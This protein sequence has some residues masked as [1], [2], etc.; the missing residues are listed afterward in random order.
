MAWQPFND[1]KRG[2]RWLIDADGV[3]QIL[4]SNARA[5]AIITYSRVVV[6]KPNDSWFLDS[7]PWHRVE[8]DWPKVRETVDK[9]SVQ[10][11]SNW[12]NLQTFEA[13]FEALV[14]FRAKAKKYEGIASDQLSLASK[15][16]LEASKAYVEELD[17][18]IKFLQNVQGASAQL[19][20]LGST[21]LTGGAAV[22]ALGA[23]S[24]LTGVGKYQETGQVGSAIFAGS[25]TM[26][27]GSLGIKPVTKG[28]T[29][30]GSKKAL[31]FVGVLA[32]STA[33]GAQALMDGKSAEGAM[34]EAA[35]SA[36]LS[37][38][39]DAL[40][41]KLIKGAF[42]AKVDLRTVPLNTRRVTEFGIKSTI[43]TSSNLLSNAAMDQAF[44]VKKDA[45]KVSQSALLD[46]AA[47]VPNS[48]QVHV[49]FV[50]SIAMK[51]A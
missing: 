2:K 1:Q 49:D 39:G 5:R 19:L 31:K 13:L 47:G 36:L 14:D 27:V 38:G 30:P 41:E 50:R 45:T 24:A 11:Y 35:K 37:V 23:G 28:L 20:V 15:I 44:E 12:K 26:I 51:P 17:K 16:S 48:N 18:S 10:L 40:S 46:T 34:A 9:E 42:P 7:P 4:R 43:G 33:S 8:V 21:I 22:A 3:R 32:D 29:S 25:A 6:E